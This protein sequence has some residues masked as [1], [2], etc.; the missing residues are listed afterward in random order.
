MPTLQ[1]WYRGHTG[2]IEDGMSYG[3]YARKDRTKIEVTELPVGVWTEDFKT[4]L[5]EYIDKNP[6]I[7]KDYESHYTE[8]TV[9]F[10]LIFHNSEIVDDLLTR[11]CHHGDKKLTKFEMDFK[12]TNTRPLNT[13]NMHLYTPKGQ[14][15]KYSDPNEILLDFYFARLDLYRTRKEHIVSS[16]ND[17]MVFMN[18]KI[19]FILGVIQDDI[20][21]MNVKKT[22]IEEYLREHEYP[23]HSES[24]D[25][26][27]KMPLFNLTYEKKE[28]LMK[29]LKSKAD[30]LDAI[31]KKDP[32]VMWYEDIQDFEKAYAQ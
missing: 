29:D 16:L 26:L 10:V 25:Y 11:I 14:I 13:N 2:K 12:M 23:L 18:A 5:E 3:V 22:V 30:M 4:H 9:H 15:K 7:L 20:K 1:P 32:K 19:K 6:R 27:I 24:Y 21:V 31:S 8:S 17:E 28:E